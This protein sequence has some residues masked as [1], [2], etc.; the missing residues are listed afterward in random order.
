MAWNGPIHNNIKEHINV[1]DVQMALFVAFINA[2]VEAQDRIDTKTGFD[3]VI[4]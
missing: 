4:S 2:F 3:C 1:S